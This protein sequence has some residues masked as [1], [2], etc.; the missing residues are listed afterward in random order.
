[1][2][3]PEGCIYNPFCFF[4]SNLLTPSLSTTSEVVDIQILTHASL[5]LYLHKILGYILY[6]SL[7]NSCKLNSDHVA[8]H[9]FLV[10]FVC[11]RDLQ[12][13]VEY[14]C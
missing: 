1:M 3:V 4:S 11:H 7:R 2:K 8:L 14:A 13:R 6:S 5:H 9:D 10:V 12:Y